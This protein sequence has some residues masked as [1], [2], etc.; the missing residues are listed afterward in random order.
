MLTYEIISTIDNDLHCTKDPNPEVKQ[1][2]LSVGMASFYEPV[3]EP[4]HEFV[5]TQG[6]LKYLTP[7]Y[8]AME[9]Q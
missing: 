2:W 3:Y 7:I 6:R 8:A 1:R 4:A 9:I 5:S